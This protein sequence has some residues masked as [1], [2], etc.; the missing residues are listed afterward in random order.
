LHIRL[1]AAPDNLVV[2]LNHALPSGGVLSGR[3]DIVVR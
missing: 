3:A 2:T 1:R